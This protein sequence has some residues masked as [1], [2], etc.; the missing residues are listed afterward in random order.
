MGDVNAEKNFESKLHWSSKSQVWGSVDLLTKRRRI[1]GPNVSFQKLDDSRE[2]LKW[3]VSFVPDGYLGLLDLAN[4][5]KN[6]SCTKI[7]RSVAQ[8]LL[9]FPH[10]RRIGG[11]LVC[12]SFPSVL[13]IPPIFCEIN[14]QMKN[15]P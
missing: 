9:F 4:A 11:N 6:H 5:D 13:Q 3:T 12:F 1:F 15:P 7:Y 8:T 14:D 10:L 2:S